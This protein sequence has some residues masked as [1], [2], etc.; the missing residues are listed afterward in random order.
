MSLNDYL[1]NKYSP[2]NEFAV[3]HVQ[4]E[5]LIPETEA[6]ILVKNI[7]QVRVIR[8]HFAMTFNEFVR[9]VDYGLR[10]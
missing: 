5:L 4:Y 3:C 10:N 9:I 1:K 7:L 6:K 8:Q 2:I